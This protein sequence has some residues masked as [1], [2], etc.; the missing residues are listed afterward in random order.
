METGHIDWAKI[1]QTLDER[2]YT[3][4]K[5]V[6]TGDEC[7]ELIKGY[8]KDDRYRKTIDMKRYRFGEGE[9]KY[10]NYPLPGPV[11]QL[12]EAV[13][14]KLSPVANRWMRTLNIAIQYPPE[15]RDFLAICHKGA[16]TRPT[17]LILKYGAGDYNTLHQDLYGEIYFPMQA[18]LFLNAPG[19]DY[20][21]GEFVLTE[22]RPRAQSKAIVLRPGKGDMLLFASNFRPV[23]GGNGYYRVSMKHGVSEVTLG[24]R[25]TVGIIF[26]DAA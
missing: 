8:P 17:P 4:A 5:G 13:Y 2:G 6:L 9:Y 21:G 1:A 7:E 26:H 24:N 12:R 10:F 3:L 14:P 22:Q 19:T 25:Y 18:V 15:L 11:Q 20:E 23:K 16:Q